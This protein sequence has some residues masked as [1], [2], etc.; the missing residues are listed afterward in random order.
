MSNTK[1]V[2]LGLLTIAPF[3]LFGMYI[4]NIFKFLLFIPEMEQSGAG[5]PPPEFLQNFGLLFIYIGLAGLLGLV[6]LIIYIIDIVN[7]KKFVGPNSSMKIVWLL[8]VILLSSIGMLVYF[9]VEIIGRKEGEDYRI[10]PIT[11]RTN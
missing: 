1:K 6:A 8:I 9:I 3:P 2:L 5:L 7:N 4:Y 11:D 10:T